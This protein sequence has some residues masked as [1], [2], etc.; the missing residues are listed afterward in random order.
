MQ[1]LWQVVIHLQHT[2]AQLCAGTIKHQKC[3]ASLIDMEAMLASGHLL[4]RALARY[5]ISAQEVF[6]GF[7]TMNLSKD[8]STVCGLGLQNSLCR[9]PNNKSAVMNP[10]AQRVF[11]FA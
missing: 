6:T 1:M 4:D 2:V 5:I 7:V 8:K 3:K 10:Q 9:L 11:Q